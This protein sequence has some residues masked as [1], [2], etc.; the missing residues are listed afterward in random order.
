MAEIVVEDTGVGVAEH[1]LPRLF[2][3]FHRIEGSRS[4]THEGSGIGLALV[5]SLVGLHG[6]AIAASSQLGVGT[7]F[8]I[9]IPFGSAH[10]PPDRVDAPTTTTAPSGAAEPST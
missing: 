6:G 10:L 8:T 5:H 2:E 1:E 4:R 9:S 3:R 7:R